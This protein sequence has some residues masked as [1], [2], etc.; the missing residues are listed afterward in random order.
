MKSML[1]G[2]LAHHQKQL[3]Y[4]R[5]LLDGRAWYKACAALELA[6]SLEE[7]FRKDGCTPKFHH[8]LQV[9]RLVATLLPH[10]MHPEE[11]IAAAF[12]HDLRE[13]H[14]KE[15]NAAALAA[16]FGPLVAEAVWA[17]SKKSGGLTKDYELY[18]AELAKDPIASIVKLCDR[19]H[20]LHTMQGVW[21]PEK[22]QAYAEE[23]DRW[24]FPMIKAARHNFPR[25][26]G[27]YENLKIILV[28]QH[29]MVF[30]LTGGPAP[31]LEVTV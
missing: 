9:A 8:Q 17:L 27:A 21:T 16:Q 14:P 13:D 11:T 3:T 30:H 18:F 1:E 28:I 12:L 20:N 10:L 7:G 6:R 23:I 31:K 22:Q 5:G 19:A 4:M 25:Q 15:V 26:Y 24:F 2:M 29:E